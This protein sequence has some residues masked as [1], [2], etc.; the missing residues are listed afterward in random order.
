MKNAKLCPFVEAV[1]RPNRTVQAWNVATFGINILDESQYEIAD[2]SV[3]I[4]KEIPP[5]SISVFHFLEAYMFTKS[6][7]K[8]NLSRQG[9][10]SRSQVIV[11]ASF[12]MIWRIGQILFNWGKVLQ[13]GPS[14]N[15]WK[16]AFKKFDMIWSF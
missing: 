10:F 12:K 11:H 2:S 5:S 13:D 15:L 16:T 4:L 7:F 3:S 14:K 6:I 9:V 1:T 8:R